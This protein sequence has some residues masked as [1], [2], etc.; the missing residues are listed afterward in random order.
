MKRRSARRTA[1]IAV[2]CLSAPSVSI[3]ESTCDE[4]SQAHAPV[5]AHFSQDLT[6]W[7]E[8]NPAI[9][10]YSLVCEDSEVTLQAVVR[11]RSTLSY[12]PDLD[13]L[14][15]QRRFYGLAAYYNQVRAVEHSSGDTAWRGWRG[16]FAA[17]LVMQ[18]DG[19]V[20][21]RDNT[22]ELT[23]GNGGDVAMKLGL[24]ESDGRGEF[25]GITSRDLRYSHLWGWLRALSL[26]LEEVLKS[27]QKITGSSWGLSV[28]LL[29]ALIK[30][31]LIP[32]SI[33]V[34]RQQRRVGRIQSALEQPLRDIKASYDGQEAHERIMAAHKELGVSPFYTLKPM[35][36]MLIQ[37]P[38]LIA[39][40]NM[41]GELPQLSGQAFWWISDLA[42]P[43]AV[44]KFP[45]SGSGVPLF[46][47]TLNLLPILMTVVTIVSA[48]IYRDH[49]AP[50][51]ETRKQKRNLYFMAIAFFVLFY[52]FPASMV[53]YWA[54]ANVL[55]V[56][57]Q[58][59]SKK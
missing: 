41:L 4:V 13:F 54:S 11:N 55:Q 7:I 33:F 23:P 19:R 22:V 18:E 37:V 35:L 53:L 32:V 2:V 16:R 6:E 30:I 46:G 28:I 59:L 43:D 58:M 45:D 10:S 51:S 52:P 9:E 12:S 42:Y 27:I 29:S 57:Q 8:S 25:G 31:A 17:A 44:L 36:G 50:A 1:A 24:I 40:F 14:S 48:I 34:A 38:I 5:M 47:S 3:A 26:I 49:V 56:V 15:E 39:V 21:V 20:L